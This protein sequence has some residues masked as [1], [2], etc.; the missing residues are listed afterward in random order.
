VINLGPLPRSFLGYGSEVP[1]T[2]LFDNLPANTV[3]VAVH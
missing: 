1:V 3:T 2:I